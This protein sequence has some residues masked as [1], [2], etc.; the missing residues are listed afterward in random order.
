MD[1]LALELLKRQLMADGLILS[2]A[3][4]TASNCLA[5]PA[6]MALS[7]AAFELNRFYNAL[8]R[9]FENIARTFENNLRPGQGYH[10]ALIERMSLTIPGVRPAFLPPSAKQPIRD[11]KSFRHFVRHAYDAPL[12]RDRI[13][14]LVDTAQQVAALH[15]DWTTMFFD[16]FPP[17]N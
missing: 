17:S 9:G 3:A 4:A 14:R 11:L 13:E 7:A 15:G 12:I 8:E 5:H 10:E 6:E 2:A 16:Q 1:A